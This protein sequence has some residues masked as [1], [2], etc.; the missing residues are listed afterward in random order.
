MS[1][2]FNKLNG[3]IWE[4]IL[5]ILSVVLVVILFILIY[6]SDKQDRAKRAELSTLSKIVAEQDRIKREENEKRQL[7][8]EEKRWL[9]ILKT[10]K[11]ADESKGT[12]IETNEQFISNSIKPQVLV[13]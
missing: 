9:E 13:A 11:W 4:Y 5:K 7:E 2:L 6:W 1:K 12:I 10:D 3:S 8:E